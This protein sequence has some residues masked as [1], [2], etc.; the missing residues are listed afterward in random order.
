MYQ[1]Y[2]HRK[3]GV[4]C[5]RRNSGQMS[6]YEICLGKCVC[7]YCYNN[8]YIPDKITDRTHGKV[9]GKFFCVKGCE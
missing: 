6:S 3:V 2:P 9:G 7:V 8:E 1:V 5:L 4:F